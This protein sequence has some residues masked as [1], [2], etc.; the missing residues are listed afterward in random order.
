MSSD[1][2]DRL[3]D[4][5]AQTP[6]TAPPVDLWDRGVRRR[7][8]RRAGSATLV[9]ALVLLLG[10]GGWTV[11]AQRDVQPSDTRGAPHMPD[12]FYE[13]SSWLS[14]FAAAPGALVAIGS[15]DHKSMLHTRRDVYGVTATDGQY[16]FLD[17]PHLA[18]RG[19]YASTVPPAL[20]P[21]GRYVGFWMT[22][23]P[24]GLAN[25]QLYGQTITGI[26]VYDATTGRTRTARLPTRHGL[27]PE[28][29]A[30]S[31]AR[32]LVMSVGQARSGDANRQRAASW[33]RVHLVVWRLED[34]LP[35]PLDAPN[36]DDNVSAGRGFVVIGQRLV[37]PR[38]PSR[39]TRM[40]APVGTA[41]TL[42]V[43]PGATQ[44]ANVA[45]P[46]NPNNLQVGR[47]DGPGRA[48]MR[49]VNQVRQ[50]YR[51]L[52]WTDDQ[53]VVAVARSRSLDGSLTAR[54]ELVDVR[55][56]SRRILTTHLAGGGNAW[57]T[58]SFASHLL[59]SP[60]AH[61]EPPPHAWNLRGV[62]LGV[63][64]LLVGLLLA[65]LMVRRHLHVIRPRRA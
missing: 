17:L 13:P 41:P 14:S 49:R 15:A 10:L 11:H 23:S 19:D 20:S 6:V 47:V 62:A 22:G 29:L 31:D 63:L 30:W 44:V 38:D 4:L 58:L 60:P 50:Y 18:D 34:P 3:G 7:R 37:W 48:K 8:A 5:A 26:G 40:H 54:L 16:G 39:D 24:S 56:G 61:A 1:L 36:A 35:V 51:P 57:D 28:S 21:D 52:V 2:R 42:V 53:H 33:N 25:T 12:R 55:S 59:T 64:G 65:V 32:T 9:A 45:G 43:S 46:R 27:A